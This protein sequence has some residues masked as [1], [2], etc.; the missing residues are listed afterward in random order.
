[1]TI[2]KN[3]ALSLIVASSVTLG[4]PQ[5]LAQDGN[6]NPSNLTSSPYTR[7]GFGKM[8]TVGNA[9][10]RGMGDVGIALRTNLYTNLYNPA[11]LTAID[12]LTMLFD[13]ALD[14]EWYTLK[15]NGASANDWNA[16][17][18]YLTFHFPLW[19]RFAGAISYMPYSMVGYEYGYLSK[20]KIDNTLVTN[21]TLST[22]KRHLGN[23]GLQHFQLS[24]AWNP[25]K[26]RTM[27]LALGATAGY[28][29]GSVEHDG[30]MVINS[31]QGVSVYDVK[32]YSC[33]GWDLT[34]G[35][36]FT[37]QIVPGKRMIYGVTYSPR[38]HIG[39]D[40]ETG[41]KIGSKDT[42]NNTMRISLSAPSKYGVGV[43]YQID[44]KLNVTAEYGMERWSDVTGLSDE[45]A[46]SES[47]YQDVNRLALGIEYRPKLYAQNYF[48]TCLY[49]AGV[50]VK[51]NYVKAIDMKEYSASCGIGMPVGKSRRSTFNFSVSY[52]HVQPKQSS[53]IKENHVS[54]TM[55]ITF[56]EMMFY[57]SRLM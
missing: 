42:L 3:L 12:T 54:L 23:G 30:N 22:T 13:T 52:T 21:D 39:C 9:S 36:Q 31:G 46:K 34:L 37:K 2:Q 44:R 47:S 57:R 14:A 5:V 17:F 1:M 43:C 25:I 24:M 48:H 32:S 35:A 49:R 53:F 28:I 51:N 55:G 6:S 50:S 40:V 8:G 20:E 38:T 7:Y 4:A 16:G 29:C 11:S 15:E 41:A 10:T 27:R 26:K 19:N 33:I 18:S 45:L 56:N